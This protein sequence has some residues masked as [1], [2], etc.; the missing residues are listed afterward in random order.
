MTTA[1]Y[2]EY[3]NST[4]WKQTRSL[5]I[6]RDQHC[7]ICHSSKNL[8]VHHNTYQRLGQEQP[9]DLVTV[10]GNCHKFIT[11]SLKER[12]CPRVENGLELNQEYW[13]PRFIEGLAGKAIALDIAQ[14][15]LSELPDPNGLYIFYGSHGMGKSGLLCSI[16][17]NCFRAGISARYARAEEILRELRSTFSND[18]DVSEYELFQKYGHYQVLAIDEVDRVSDTRWSRSALFSLLDM[19]YNLRNQLATLLAMNCNPEEMPAGFEYLQSRMMDG[20]RVEM[21]GRDLRNSSEP[22]EQKLL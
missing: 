16:V 10:C 6:E 9:G 15:L 12:K 8:E 20:Q 5:I 17:A 7:M 22:V 11:D 14:D 4:E 13:D 3:L 18:S 19:R 1:D 21:S 2:E